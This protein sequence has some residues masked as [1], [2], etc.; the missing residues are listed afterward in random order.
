MSSCSSECGSAC[1]IGDKP[2][3]K[4]SPEV[5]RSAE[6]L[7]ML[8]ADTPEFQALGR[9]SRAVRLDPEVVRM[10]NALQERAYA[11]DPAAVYGDDLEE[12]LEALPVVR[13]FRGA[14]E[15]ARGLFAAVDEAIS[16]TCGLSFARLAKPSGHG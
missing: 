2:V 3:Y 8:L 6:A 13:E 9:W 11:Y 14:E 15:Q 5:T 4:D 10:V 7:G 12:Q 16:E 1:G